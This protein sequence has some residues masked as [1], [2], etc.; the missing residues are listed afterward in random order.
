MSYVTGREDDRSL[1]LLIRAESTRQT[2]QACGPARRTEDSV[3]SGRRLAWQQAPCTASWN[4]A[5]AVG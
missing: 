5:L 3:S 2:T 4:Q 1:S